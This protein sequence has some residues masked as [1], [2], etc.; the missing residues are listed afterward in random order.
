MIKRRT[1]LILGA[2]SDIGL[3]VVKR[4]LN[5][6]WN[7]FAHCNSNEKILKSFIVKEILLISVYQFLNKIFTLRVMNIHLVLMK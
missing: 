1:V 7:V 2:S 6:G 3:E 5:S 4:F